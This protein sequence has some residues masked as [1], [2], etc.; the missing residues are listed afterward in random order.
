MNCTSVCDPFLGWIFLA[1]WLSRPLEL[2]LCCIVSKYSIVSIYLGVIIP[3]IYITMEITANFMPLIIAG[4]ALCMLLLL[5]AFKDFE[6]FS[7]ITFAML[8][9]FLDVTTDI[10]LIIEWIQ[11]DKHIFWATIQTIIILLSQIIA[12]MKMGNFDNIQHKDNYT[13]ELRNEISK[14]DRFI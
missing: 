12:S 14:L 2:I 7:M 13:L 10:S 1:V 11:H 8:L 4:C 3:T 9:Q 6:K 5:S